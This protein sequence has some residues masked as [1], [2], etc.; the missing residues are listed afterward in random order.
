MAEIILSVSYRDFKNAYSGNYGAYRSDKM[1]EASRAM[2][3]YEAVVANP[4][5]APKPK[6][7]PKLGQLT[8]QKF[9]AN[10]MTKAWDAWSKTEEFR[11]VNA[12]TNNMCKK[13]AVEMGVLRNDVEDHTAAFAMQGVRRLN[14]KKRLVPAVTETNQ[15]VPAYMRALKKQGKQVG[16]M[17]IDAFGTAQDLKK[18]GFEVKYGSEGTSV[19]ENIQTVLQTARDERMML[20]NVTMGMAFPMRVFS[21]HFPPRW[22]TLNKPKQGLFDGTDFD[23]NIESFNL[24]ALVVMGW[25][26]NQCVATGIFGTVTLD[27]R[28]VMGLLDLGL[29]IVTSRGLLGSCDRGLEPENGWPYVGFPPK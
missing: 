24:D 26:A 14:P 22:I 15:T 11:K 17:L 9:A 7:D 20:I 5:S 10:A 28:Y 3:D 13:L 8:P 27:G 19:L 18:N 21:D 12:R 4:G 6:F 1:V 23:N 29:T 25:D 16:V 2:R